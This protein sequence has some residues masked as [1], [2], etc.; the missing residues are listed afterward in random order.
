MPASLHAVQI[1]ELYPTA[2]GIGEY[3][4][5]CEIQ[6]EETLGMQ[7]CHQSCHAADNVVTVGKM[8]IPLHLTEG[9]RQVGQAAGIVT[10]L[11]QSVPAMFL[12]GQRFGRQI[13]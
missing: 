7:L 5:P 9:V 10:V 11:Q 8:C 2:V 1:D 12:I 4:P 3:I 13:T 6:R